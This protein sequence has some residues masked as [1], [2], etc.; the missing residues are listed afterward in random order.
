M[1][2]IPPFDWPVPDDDD[3]LSAGAAT[4]RALAAAIAAD[5]VAR[6]PEAQGSLFLG[7]IR[8]FAAEALVP[9]NWLVCDGRTIPEQHPDLIAAIGPTTPD[10]TDRVPMGGG[11]PGEAGGA[12][13]ATLALANLPAHAHTMAHTH[14]IN[15]GHLG[16]VTGSGGSH[17]HTLAM[18]SSV[19][20]N[21]HPPTGQGSGSVTTTS[22][23]AVGTAAAHTHTVTVP[24]FTGS[25]GASSAASTGSAGSGTAVDTTPAHVRV[26]FAIYGGPPA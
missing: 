13:E 25:S 7:E 15:H 16:N 5:L 11:T 6:T 17:T 14:T 3:L 24:S 19:S 26:V 9:D 20:T 8:T 4:I 1:T 22:S 18:T 2:T 23:A 21:A 12:N 10:L